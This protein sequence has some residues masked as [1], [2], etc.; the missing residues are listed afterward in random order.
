MMAVPITPGPQFQPGVPQPL[1][2][3]RQFGINGTCDVSA[4]G[5]FLLAMPVEQ[6]ASSP[7]TVVLN[8]RQALTK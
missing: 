1:F 3:A 8:W 5:R 6:A 4:D 7:M 2:D